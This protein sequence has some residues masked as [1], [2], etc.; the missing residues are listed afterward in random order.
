M[1]VLTQKPVSC[2]SHLLALLAG[3]KLVPNQS[4]I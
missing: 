3:P 2:V 4:T 1:D